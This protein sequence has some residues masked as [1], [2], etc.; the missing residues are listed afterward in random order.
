GIDIAAAAGA[1]LVNRDRM[2][3]YTEG[4]HNWDP[5]WPGHGIRILP[6][7]SSLWLDALGRRLPA[8]CLPGY[9]TISTLKYLR[10]TADIAQYDHSWLVLTERILA[11][12]FALSGSEQNPDITSGAKLEVLRQRLAKGVPGPVEAF[13]RKGEDFVV[14]D[15]IEGLVARMNSLTDE[16]LL[17]AA[18]VRR[19]VEARDL[20]VNNRFSKDAQVQGIRN[21]RAFLGD[22]LSRTARPHRFLDP[23]QAPLIGVKI[24]VLTR[25]TLGGIQTDLES[26]ALSPDGQP[27]PGLYAAG[28]AAGFGGGGVHGY[29][30][31]E[32]TFL[33]GCLFSGRQ[34]GRAAAAA[35]AG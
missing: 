17:D 26:R 11:K 23:A 29:N 30:S 19:Q 14:A 8:P 34:A 20:Q 7:P 22:R 4:L 25:K 16:P 15:T 5:V 18:L 3:H 35:V 32:G 12:E 24:H 1:R 9:D 27:V 10:T 6:G 33:G 13:R 31:L 2:W 28:E 21:S